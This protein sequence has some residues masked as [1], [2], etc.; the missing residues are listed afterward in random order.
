MAENVSNKYIKILQKIGVS[1]K[2]ICPK[3]RD[4]IEDLFDTTVDA[5][6]TAIRQNWLP[7]TETIPKH[8][9]TEK[10]QKGGSYQINAN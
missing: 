1:E 7:K 8:I 9:V 3:S 10:T 6:T 4:Y 5:Q 2:S